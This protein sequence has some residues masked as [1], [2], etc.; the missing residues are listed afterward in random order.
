LRGCEQTFA[1]HSRRIKL[2][3]ADHGFSQERKRLDEWNRGRLLDKVCLPVSFISK[4]GL[5]ERHGQE[6]IH[7][8]H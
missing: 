5:L 3:A 6:K 7:P 4:K 1:V 8:V 2:S